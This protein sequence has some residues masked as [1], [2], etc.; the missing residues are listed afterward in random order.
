MHILHTIR[1]QEPITWLLPLYFSNGPDTETVAF[2]SEGDIARGNDFSHPDV[3][4]FNFW[5][6]MAPWHFVNFA[7]FTRDRILT[8]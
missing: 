3:G 7:P 4:R 2:D 8:N 6:M 1:Y 5:E